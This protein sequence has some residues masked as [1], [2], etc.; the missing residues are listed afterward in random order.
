MPQQTNKSTTILGIETSCDETSV[1]VLREGKILANET[2]T[3][4]EHTVHGGVVPELASRAHQQMIFPVVEKALKDAGVT[5]NE[6]DAISYTHG[7]GLIGSLLV[8]A[9]F[10]KGLSMAIS[11]PLIP[12]N[13]MEAHVLA[14]LIKDP[15]IEENPKFP[16][17]CLTVSGGHTQLIQVHSAFE[18]EVLGETIDDAAGEAF[19]KAAKIFGLPYPGGPHLDKIAQ[20]GNPDKFTFSKPR[21]SD[22]NFSFS[23]LKTSVLYFVRD[24]VNKDPEFIQKNLADLC[25]S[26]QKTIVDILLEGFIKA[27]KKTGSKRIALSGGVS[28][29]SELRKRTLALGKEKNL[30]TFTLPLEYCTDNAAMIAV[31]GYL[32]FIEG[33]VSSDL[34]LTPTARYAIGSAGT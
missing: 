16:F 32:K 28:A 20:M 24:Q 1:A 21:V 17:L 25:A 9:S 18:F 5:L 13:H 34:S 27:I 12:V 3:Q 10:A 31:S 6:L 19:D 14:H 2:S 4:M 7:P 15:R 33:N 8:G 26:V 22:L 23:G 29:N 30:K 11:K